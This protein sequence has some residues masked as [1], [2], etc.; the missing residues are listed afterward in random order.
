MNF[1]LEHAP[2]RESLL[3][4]AACLAIVALASPVSA[5]PAPTERVGPSWLS[6]SAVL[7]DMK[8]Q[9]GDICRISAPMDAR[10]PVDVAASIDGA[11]V[12]LR[13]AA[14]SVFSDDARIV[15]VGAGGVEHT[16]IVERVTTMR[17]DIPELP[18]ATVAAS[19]DE[20]GFRAMLLLP[21]GST[22]WIEPLKG[23]VE[24]A[25]TDDFVVYRPEDSPCDGGLCGAAESFANEAATSSSNPVVNCGGLCVAQL[26]VDTDFEFNLRYG[27]ATES[28]ITSVINTA[29]V[30]YQ[31][32]LALTFQVTQLVL[33]PTPDDPYPDTI[34][35]A[36]ALSSFRLYWNANFASVPRSSTLLFTGKNFIGSVVGIAQ[37]GTACVASAGYCLAGGVTD[38]GP[39]LACA[40]NITAHELGHV[41]GALTHCSCP[42][43]TMNTTNT[44]ATTFLNNPDTVNNSHA[45][46]SAR[47]SAASC[48][49]PLEAGTTTIPFADTFPGPAVNNQLWT[50]VSGAFITSSSIAPPSAPKALELRGGATVRSAFVN[51]IYLTDIR[52]SFFVERGGAGSPPGAGEDLVFEWL[53][54]DGVWH[55]A[56]RQAGTGVSASSFTAVD[57]VLPAAAGHS[58]LR[59]R[60]RNLGNDP[61]RDSWFVDD[62]AVTGTPFPV[63]QVSLLRPADGANP[64]DVKPSFAWTNAANATGYR[65][66]VDNAPDF[67]T[68]LSDLQ[69]GLVNSYEWAGAPLPLAAT[70]YWRVSAVNPVSSS[71][72]ETRSFSTIAGAP[73]PFAMTA[74]PNGIV[75]DARTIQLA[76]QPATN[77]VSYDLEVSTS[78]SF[79]PSVFHITA[80]VPAPASDAGV[81]LTPLP[82][83][84]DQPVYTRVIAKNSLGQSVTP[85]RTFYRVPPPI[86]GT[87]VLV[88]PLDGAF[89]PLGAVFFL[90]W[91]PDPAAYSY[92][93]QISECSDFQSLVLDG[94]TYN[95][96]LLTSFPLF[97]YPATFH[98]FWRVF[99]VNT[100]GTSAPV[101]GGGNFYSALAPQPIVPSGFGLISPPDQ[102]NLTTCGSASS[103]LTW[104]QP[105]GP[106]S[107]TNYRLQIDDD[108]TFASPEFDRGGI[109]SRQ[110]NVDFA[111]IYGLG[112]STVFWRVIAT[113]ANGAQIATA[114]FSFGWATALPSGSSQPGQFSLL[115]PLDHAVVGNGPFAVAW[116]PSTNATSYRVSVVPRDGRPAI[117]LNGQRGTSIIVTAESIGGPGEYDLQVV[118]RGRSGAVATSDKRS[119]AVFEPDANGDDQDDASN[120]MQGSGSFGQSGLDSLITTL[121]STFGDVAACAGNDLNGDGRIDLSDLL[122]AL[123]T[124][125][126]SEEQ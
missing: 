122:V 61:V 56:N 25:D 8:L 19:V 97:A 83:F 17:G 43:S 42:N 78:E 12:T 85:T 112:P 9:G 4:A 55:E 39:S 63:G 10:R 40:S 94:E 119:F 18:G 73:G 72:S 79:S 48:I 105:A 77:A 58:T 91:N 33:R 123:R 49:F 60:F 2:D 110:S 35:S 109:A 1:T 5:D 118:A 34:D 121:R 96:G 68:P 82:L 126:A 13:L 69:V 81:D 27:G 70:L 80:T 57:L 115:T 29:N 31:S 59:M 88:Q 104:T 116:T 98:K 28:W 93:V 62:F 90:Q 74:P 103:L 41:W 100:S 125:Q 6:R 44:C 66:T 67:A 36:I 86:P 102:T 22:R 106:V 101:Y 51:A 107:V 92:R 75:T 30:R 20:T 26:G 14:Y 87:P 111:S 15:T 54:P 46:I 47:I 108:P 23:R 3:V 16:S 7:R 76:W 45:A 113:K 52:A 21:D 32:E 37:S 71:V 114:P 53:G 38:G 117:A 24:G 64:L 99:A 124:M 120:G 95:P 50:G 89:M 11:T 84:L 65:L